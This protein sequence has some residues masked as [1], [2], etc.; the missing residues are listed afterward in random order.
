MSIN[1]VCPHCLTNEAEL[2]HEKIVNFNVIRVWQ[3]EDCWETYKTSE[4]SMKDSSDFLGKTK[5]RGINQRFILNQ[6]LKQEGVTMNYYRLRD[7]FKLW[8]LKVEGRE[9][10]RQRFSEA[11]QSLG[12][13]GLIHSKD[14]GTKVILTV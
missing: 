3:C 8:C 2:L 7:A 12:K 1:P 14:R 11:L 5:I 9:Y 4:S 13:R 10:R 6:L